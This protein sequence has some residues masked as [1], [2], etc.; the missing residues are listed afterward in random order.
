MK[1]Q[2]IVK[3]LKNQKRNRYWTTKFKL[4][5]KRAK[6]VDNAAKFKADIVS[7]KDDKRVARVSI[8][9]DLAEEHGIRLN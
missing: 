6:Y 1:D 7:V 4:I 2:K 8:Q 3:V 5:A 9:E